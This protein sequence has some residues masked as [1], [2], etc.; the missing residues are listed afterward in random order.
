MASGSKSSASQSLYDQDVKKECRSRLIEHAVR[1]LTTERDT[2]ACVQRDH[3]QRVWRQLHET[4]EVQKYF[5]SLQRQEIEKEIKQWEIFRESQIQTRKPS[6]LRV[7]Y[8]AGDNP[9]NDLEVLIE[10]GVLTQNVWAVEKDSATLKTAW[11]SIN[12]SHL[13]NVRLFKGD[14]LTFLKDFEG[15]FDIIYYDACGTLPS[16]K[17]NTLKFIG[18]VFLYNKLKSP[19]ALITNFSF[20]PK[21]T[22]Q[23]QN[24]STRD[25]D[26]ERKLVRGLSEEYLKYRL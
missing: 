20:P 19:G 10:N 23:V 2:S 16:A 12:R 22:A 9:I 7:C 21:Q 3:V 15:Q 11:E 13:R 24:A 17:Q 26:S 25:E 14:I 6:D 8:L 1:C 5:S 18:Y 4:G